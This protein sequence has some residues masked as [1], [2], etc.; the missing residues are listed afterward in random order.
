MA[1]EQITG[2]RAVDRRSDLYMLGGVAYTLLTGQPPF[3]EETAAEVM[4]AHVRNAVVPPSRHRPDIP[5][6]LE[7]VVLRCLAK[8]P[9]ERFQGAEDLETGLSACTSASDWDARKAVAWW[10]EF[11]PSRTAERACGGRREKDR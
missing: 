11:E 6:D 1:P 10:E 2:D 7:G 3:M 4:K 8:D 9:E 5:P